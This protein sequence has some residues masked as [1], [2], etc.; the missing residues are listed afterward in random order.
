MAEEEMRNGMR[1]LIE[2]I[3]KI[4]V[5]ITE[6]AK[7]NSELKKI[8][9]SD[10]KE[11]KTKMDQILKEVEGTKKCVN[12]NTVRI[13]R[14]EAEKRKRNVVIFGLPESPGER[15]F[16]LEEK[17][18]D[19]LRNKLRADIKLEEIDFVTRMGP[20]RQGTG[21]PRGVL[22]SLTTIRRKFNLLSLKKNLKGT[23]LYLAEHFSREI[24][25]KRKPLL[26]EAKKLRAEGK[27]ATVRYDKLYW[28]ERQTNSEAGTSGNRYGGKF[29]QKQDNTQRDHKYS[30][31]ENRMKRKPSESPN[32]GD[33]TP[34]RIRKKK[35]VGNKKKEDTVYYTDSDEFAEENME[36]VLPSP[37]NEEEDE[38]EEERDREEN[39]D[40]Q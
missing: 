28:E 9:L 23:N 37:A 10:S 16:E 32:T 25:Q 39:Y 20:E 5:K 19:I 40:E 31:E 27:F 36:V 35:I 1:T 3:Q 33:N 15:K 14:I 11:V 4:N 22:L 29:T 21:K 2:Q 34:T 8:L 13:D 17:I 38:K 7:E 30:T 18:L 12:Q 26:E 6:D 24:T